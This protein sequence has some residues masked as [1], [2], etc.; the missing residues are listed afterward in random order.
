MPNLND[1]HAYKSTNGGSGG[2]GGGRIGCAAWIVIAVVVFLLFFFI[3]EGA[4]WEAIECLLAFGI[5]AFMFVR[6]LFN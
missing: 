4:S 6:W 1:Y 5:I 2:S 3:A